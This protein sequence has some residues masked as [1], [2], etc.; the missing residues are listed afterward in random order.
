[1]SEPRKVVSRAQAR[2]LIQLAATGQ[3]Q[4]RDGLSGASV[5]ANMFLRSVPF[6]TLPEHV[7]HKGDRDG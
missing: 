1:M 4:G 6:K 3:I 5:V 7:E 2:K